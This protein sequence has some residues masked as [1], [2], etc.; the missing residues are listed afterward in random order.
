MEFEMYVIYD[1]TKNIYNQPM[2]ASN[3]ADAMRT[4]AHESK[5]I[6]FQFIIH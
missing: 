3:D 6:S 1:A 5:H 2:C 4:L